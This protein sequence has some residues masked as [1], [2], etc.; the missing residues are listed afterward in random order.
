[1]AQERLQCAIETWGKVY[2]EIGSSG[3]IGGEGSCCMSEDAE[4]PVEGQA[5]GSW[6]NTSSTV[7]LS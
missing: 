4:L 6:Q 3:M 5:Q 2:L 7:E 1:M